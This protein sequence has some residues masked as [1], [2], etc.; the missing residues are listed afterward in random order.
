M[1]QIIMQSQITIHGNEVEES[2]IVNWSLF[3]YY[4]QLKTQEKTSQW[5]F[6]YKVNSVEITPWRDL[7]FKVT[8]FGV[9]S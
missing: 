4:S 9:K 6:K 5:G 2:M 1:L 8:F 7:K 3:R